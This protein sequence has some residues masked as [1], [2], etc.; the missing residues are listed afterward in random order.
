MYSRIEMMIGVFAFGAVLILSHL[1]NLSTVF[2]S[3]VIGPHGWHYPSFSSA[4]LR[5]AVA[6]V[7]LSPSGLSENWSRLV[8]FTGIVFFAS[9]FVGMDMEIV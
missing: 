6:L 7:L 1:E 8:V 9:S 3:Y 5:Y 2:S 4:A